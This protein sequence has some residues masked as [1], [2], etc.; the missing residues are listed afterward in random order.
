MLNKI[1]TYCLTLIVT[2]AF[3]LTAIAN[4]P[5]TRS[6]VAD[7]STRSG[8]STQ[9]L[10]HALKSAHYL[11]DVITKI[12]TPYESKTYDVYQQ[13]F[14]TEP[15]INAGEKFWHQHHALLKKAHKSYGVDPSV[16][17]AILGAESFYGKHEGSTS[18]LSALYTLAFYY[19][20]RSHFFKEE[21]R[22][23]LVMCHNQGIKPDRILGSYAGAFGMPQFMP[24]SYRHYGVDASHN[25]HID[26]MHDDADVIMSVAN[27]LKH[28]DWQAH[29][30]L[31]VKIR[32][33]L[34]APIPNRFITAHAKPSTTVGELRRHGILI[35]L[36]I[37]DSQ[38]ASVIQL[39]SSTNPEYWV[40]FPN[41]KSILHYNNSLNYAM[42]VTQLA[43]RIQHIHEQ[44]HAS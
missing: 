37:K 31:A 17:I 2:A 28:A 23:F 19:P 16:I 10:E 15:R 33:D 36:K 20:S 4:Q 41:F 21:L 14:L 8:I 11:P 26:L 13:H 5:D 38:A 35:P 44:R 40:T 7:L 42:M 3:T 9:E 25:H 1:I 32:T 27:F 29:T 30:P 24:S 6:F 12:S 22:Q 43:N 34:S 39:S 18:V